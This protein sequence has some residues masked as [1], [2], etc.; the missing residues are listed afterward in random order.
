MPT[1]E[2]RKIG[3]GQKG[4]SLNA[5]KI[6]SKRRPEQVQHIKKKNTINVVF[7]ENNLQNGTQKEQPLNTSR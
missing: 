7:H 5:V 4:L 6:K 3:K 2:V 1:P